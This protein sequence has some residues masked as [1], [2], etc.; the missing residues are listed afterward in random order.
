MI[1]RLIVGLIALGAVFG[2]GR[3]FARIGVDLSR[4]NRL[5]QM[6]GEPPLPAK[7]MRAVFVS[8]ARTARQ[9]KAGG[10]LQSLQHDALRYARIKSM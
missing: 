6:S 7:L 1:G 10:F 3:S 2:L 4:Y 5:D 9:G 8:A